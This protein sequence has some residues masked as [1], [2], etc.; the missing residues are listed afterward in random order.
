M[1]LVSQNLLNYDM[2]FPEDTVLRVNLAWVDSIEKLEETLSISKSDFF[3][4]LPSGRI[5]PPNNKY[6]IED[7]LPV[8]RRYN[9][10]KFLAISNVETASVVNDYRQLV[11]DQLIIVPKI[12]TIKGIKN[13]EVIGSSLSEKKYIMLDH[14]DLFTNVVKN[15]EGP[16]YF[17]ELVD[18]LV[19][20]CKKSDICL[21]RARGIIFSN[22]I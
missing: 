13:I 15:G 10:V 19:D 2:D 16:N 18:D 9:N 4:D 1:F 11:N 5:K 6:E 17:I 22:E 14:D 20:F 8:F 7:L 3:I 21:L 12:E